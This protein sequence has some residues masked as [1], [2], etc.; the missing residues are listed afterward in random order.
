M[1]QEAAENRTDLAIVLTTISNEESAGILARSLIELRL[2]ACVNIVPKIRSI[3]RWEGKVCDDAEVLM[4]V[5]T[6]GDRASAL[7]SHLEERHP[8]DTPEIV[9]LSPDQ[10]SQKYADWVRENAS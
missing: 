5:K 7:L 4:I 8:Y 9:L 1:D 6:R 2:A 10:V 3:Y